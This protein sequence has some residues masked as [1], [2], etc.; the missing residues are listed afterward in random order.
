MHDS[1]ETRD[2]I[3]VGQIWKDERQS[4]VITKVF[5]FGDEFY[6]SAVFEDGETLNREDISFLDDLTFVSK[7]GKDW[8]RSLASL[9]ENEEMNE[10]NRK[11]IVEVLGGIT[12]VAEYCGC[13]RMTIYN[14]I[15]TGRM[16]KSNMLNVKTLLR[17]AGLENGI[18]GISEESDN[19][20][21]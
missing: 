18:E 4:F 12:T 1:E 15:R 21:D 16:N 13:S 6:F 20:D 17:K 3:K 5:D 2:L 11:R 14:W 19:K 8:F 9:K 10:L 7:G